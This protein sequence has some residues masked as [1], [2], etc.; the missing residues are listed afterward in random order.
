VLR[1]ILKRGKSKPFWLGHPWVFSGAVHRVEGK[2]SEQGGTCL[3]IDERDNVVGWGHHNPHARIA[4]RILEHRRTTEVDFTPPTF[5]TFLAQRLAQARACREQLGLPNQKTNAYR[6]VNAEGDGL[7]GLIVDVYG[8]RAVMQLNSRA[9]A[10]NSSE[11]A[12]LVMKETGVRSVQAMVSAHGLKFEGIPPQNNTF[13]DKTEATDVQIV[14]NGVRFQVDLK[15]PQK[16]GFYIDQRDNRRLLA[17]LCSGKDVLDLYCHAGGFGLHALK[18]GAASATFVDS[19][20]PALELV[21]KNLELNEVDGERFAVDAVTFLKNAKERGRSWDIISC[22]PPKFV[23]ARNHRDDGLKK[24]ARLNHLALS[25]L[26]PGGMLLTCSCSEHVNRDDFLRML[27]EA[28]HRMRRSIRVH[29][30]LGQGADHPYVSVAPQSDYLKAFL[31]T[32][33]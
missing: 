9:M 2:G 26:K 23:R 20:E 3:V 27:T 19:S 24:Y 14:E 32:L 12:T 18:S 25:L 29:H 28:A 5:S 33:I 16:T 10:E 1:V 13:G 8:D 15:N 22:D 21:S 31:V 11:I 7:S 6:L 4:V 30:V 17:S